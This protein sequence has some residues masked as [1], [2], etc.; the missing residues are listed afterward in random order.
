M[1]AAWAGDV[2][3]IDELVSRGADT[4]FTNQGDTALSLAV[5]A[6]HEAIVQKLT[7]ASRQYTDESGDYHNR[8]GD[9]ETYWS[10]LLDAAKA[11]NNES[12]VQAISGT[13]S[14]FWSWTGMQGHPPLCA[15]VQQDGV[16]LDV[17]WA[18][19]LLSSKDACS[20]QCSV[21]MGTALMCAAT[22]ID[23]AK[24]A[25]LVKVIDPTSTNALGSNG[26]TLLNLL[27]RQ[28]KK[29][30]VNALLATPG[31]KIKAKGASLQTALCCA[32]HLGDEGTVD[33]LLRAAGR[34]GSGQGCWSFGDIAAAAASAERAGHTKVAQKILYE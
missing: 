14:K 20:A 7:N 19:P 21:C 3:Q 1:R 8:E 30:S 12:I 5:A 29:D 27:I 4:N 2:H 34:P 25:P 26:D 18:S 6:G 32:A 10:T 13:S 15:L 11:A 28:G 22:T 16:V 17:V 23:D 33:L 9:M 31:L 24:L